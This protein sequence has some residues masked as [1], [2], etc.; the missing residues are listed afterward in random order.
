MKN[1]F[2]KV[3]LVT[4]VTLNSSII[5]TAHAKI[6][7]LIQRDIGNKPN[8]VFILVDDLGKE[9][10]DAYGGKDIKLPNVNKLAKTG[11]TF[12]NVYSMPQCT[13]S[14]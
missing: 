5:Y 14:R 12:H 10:V 1:I 7:S 6:P 13:P 11:M 4:T 8:V 2:K 3:A 9:W